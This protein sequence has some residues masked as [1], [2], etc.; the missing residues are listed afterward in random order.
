[1]VCMSIIHE[2]EFKH[3]YET[4]FLTKFYVNTTFEKIRRKIFE[5]L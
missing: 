1:M 4:L 2:A 5:K 3:L